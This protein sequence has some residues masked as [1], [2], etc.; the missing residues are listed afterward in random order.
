[1]SSIK[2]DLFRRDFT[3]NTLAIQLN[4]NR[5]GMLIDFFT[6]MRDLKEKVVR[7]L[8][9]LSF[10]EDPT[11]V[12]RA[13]R[14]EKRFGFTIGKLTLGLIENAV[15]MDFFKRLS[16]R[17]VFA[18]LRLILS[19]ENPVPALQRLAEFRLLERLHPALDL[20]ENKL[21]LL[22]STQ[23]VLSW[24]DLL[25]LEESYKKWA[26]YFLA[27]TRGCDP[28]TSAE[29][30]ERF[31]LA[32]RHRKLFVENRLQAE[33]SLLWLQRERQLTASKVYRKLVS[34]RIELVLFMMAATELTRIKRAISQYITHLRYVRISV[35]GK[36]LKDR[37]L[38]PGPMYRQ[39]LDAVQ[40]EKLNGKLASR[41]E[42]M[43][44]VDRMIA[45]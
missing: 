1:M 29:I 21:A 41:K 12:F 38:E 25:F 23:N 35:T 36:D 15:R 45:S 31:E 18:E 17:R 27:L 20:D 8:H 42:E 22:T 43:A 44:F 34:L 39:I 13:I 4:P 16:G 26:V 9:S 2:L 5:F 19:E 11:R 37:G 6:A 3:I 30:C 24:Y 10:V 32:P 40:D 33:R 14:F 7:V 28:S